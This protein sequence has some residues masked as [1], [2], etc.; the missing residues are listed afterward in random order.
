MRI[1]LGALAIGKA[2]GFARGN[3]RRIKPAVLPAIDHMGERARGPT[4]LVDI[5][6][7]DH[8]LQETDLIIRIENGEGRFQANQL[9]M[10]AQNFG[11]DGME[12][13]E[14]GHAL[15]RRASQHGNAL[16]HLTRGFIGKSH[17]ENFM[18]PRT[19]GS[20]N[21]RDTCG[22]H[23]R[24]AR[25]SAS[26]NQ[27]GTIN[28]F[29]SC[30]LLGVQH[31]EIIRRARDCGLRTRRQTTGLGRVAQVIVKAERIGHGHGFQRERAE[32]NKNHSRPIWGGGAKKSI[33]RL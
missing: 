31:R 5:I 18:R 23:T 22:E 6:G 29:H 33:P 32:Q 30:A 17:R 2:H 24:L 21:M 11:R 4:L 7:L 8:L 16:F 25:A 15:A 28:R 14:P 3:T 9:G 13:P 1:E 27:H 19:V 10:T 12:S 26:Q 20:Q